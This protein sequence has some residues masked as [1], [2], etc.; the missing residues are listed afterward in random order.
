M[1]DRG[2]AIASPAA[3]WSCPGRRGTLGDQRPSAPGSPGPGAGCEGRDLFWLRC[4]LSLPGGSREG[5]PQVYVSDQVH[6]PESEAL[7]NGKASSPPGP[8]R[9]AALLA[10]VGSLAC[11]GLWVLA[12]S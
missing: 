2:W 3:R 10:G 5:R 8:V 11:G 7:L 9:P 6:I 12:F 4:S 1:C